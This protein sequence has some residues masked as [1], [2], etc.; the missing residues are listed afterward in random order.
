M[1]K[2]YNVPIIINADL[3]HKPPTIPNYYWLNDKSGI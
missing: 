3:G 1:L 2:E